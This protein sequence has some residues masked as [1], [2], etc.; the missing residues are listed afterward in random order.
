MPYTFY[1]VGTEF[2][3]KRDFGADGSFVTT[4]FKVAVLPLYP[5]KTVRVV[6]GKSSMEYH[7]FS[8][9]WHTEYSVLAQSKINV[10]QAVYVFGY[11]AFHLAYLTG[12][13]FTDPKWLL[14]KSP[15]VSPNWIPQFA[16]FVLPAIIPLTMRLL[17]RR[18]ASSSAIWLCPCGSG[19]PYKSCCFA[20]SQ[21]LRNRERHFYKTFT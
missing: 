10:R 5:I 12:L 18:R 8:S 2:I 6:E 7:V 20:H 13:A 4:E 14:Q 3:G 9:T 21:A 15:I 1:G 16:V 17:A 11:A 19:M